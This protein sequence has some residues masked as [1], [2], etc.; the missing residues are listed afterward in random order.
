VKAEAQDGG[1]TNNANFNTPA[2]GTRGKMQMYNWSAAPG[3]LI[4][5]APASVAGTY[6][7]GLADFGRTVNSLGPNFRGNLVKVND[8]SAKPTRG[9][10]PLLNPAALNGNIALID[11][12]KCAF[13]IKVKLA[14]D[15]GAR[16]VVIVDSLVTATRRYSSRRPSATSSKPCLRQ[17][18]Q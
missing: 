12:G 17:A 10:N 8:G 4:V 14:Q 5:A 2:D 13:A 9:C 18:A 15:A 16:M 7:A 1:G 6:P 3:T 11:R